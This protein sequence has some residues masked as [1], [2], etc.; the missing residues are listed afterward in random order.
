MKQKKWGIMQ[1]FPWAILFLPGCFSGSLTCPSTVHAPLGGLLTILCNYT[2]YS[3]NNKYCCRGE[4]WD[5]S[6]EKIIATT[7]SSPVEKQGRISI[8]D[9]HSLHQFRIIIENLTLEDAGKYWCGIDIS[10][11][12]DQYNLVTVEVFRVH[13]SNTGLTDDTSSSP[14]KIELF[15][16][17]V[18]L[19]LMVVLSV[20]GLLVMWRLKK[21]KAAKACGHSLVPL[22][23]D[24]S[25]AECDVSN[26]TIAE[27]VSPNDKTPSLD[28]NQALNCTVQVEYTSVI[29]TAALPTQPQ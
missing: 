15:L 9:T 19:V 26:A 11:G 23:Q 22:S 20:G 28:S 6:C 24:P 13:T 29:R 10:L 21:R 17:I 3:T 18:L 12:Y 7:K 5:S 27:N 2:D 1:L 14:L 4:T 16:P 8:N 25:R